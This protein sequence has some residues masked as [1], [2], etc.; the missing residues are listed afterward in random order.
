MDGT[1]LVNEVF[2]NY[3]KS[4]KEKWK[5]YFSYSDIIKQ[6]KNIKNR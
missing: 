2:E 4:F 3:K 5:T 6:T 1:D